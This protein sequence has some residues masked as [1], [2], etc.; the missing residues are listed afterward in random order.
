MRNLNYQLKQICQRN[1]DG[2][3]STQA[4]RDR[5]LS[6]AADQLHEL[7]FR[8]LEAPNLKPKHIEALVAK[9]QTDEI[10]AGT[11]KNRMAHLRWLA[12]KIGKQNI[13]EKSNDAY[14]IADRKYV[15]NVSKARE[16]RQDELGKLSDPYTAASLRLQAVFGL[17]REESIKIQPCWADRGDKLVLKDTWTKGGRARELPIHNDLQRTVLNQAKALAGKGSLIP[18]EFNYKQQLNRFKNQCAAAGIHGVHGHRHHYAQTRY[19][20]L[21]GLQAP[22]AGGPTSKQLSAEQ[23]AVDRD[24]RLIISQ[25]LGHEREQI[26]A[27]YL[28]R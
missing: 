8:N 23:K 22:A 2:S 6:L 15:S 26:T 13:I 17:R 27:V 11:I 5:I 1:Q 24:A 4:S 12:E 3:F 20:E 10:G 18:S 16:L 7:G 21:T 9:W 28:G 14:G 19:Q 25:E